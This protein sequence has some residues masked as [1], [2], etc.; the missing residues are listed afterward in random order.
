MKKAML[1]LFL[2]ALSLLATACSLAH[3]P[4]R[5]VV[6]EEGTKQ[7]LAGATVYVNWISYGSAAGVDSRTSCVRI[8]FATTDA[9][10]RF[11]LPWYSPLLPWGNAAAWV[12]AYK[13]GYERVLKLNQFGDFEDYQPP[14]AEQKIAMKS[15]RGT[16]KERLVYL[17]SQLGKEC[18]S[19]Y[20]YKKKLILYYRS[21]YEVGKAI[22]S[23]PDERKIVGSL[24]FSVEDLEL[25]H[26]EVLNRLT[27]G[28]YD[29]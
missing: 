4:I 27:S 16:V 26:K 11:E 9:Q 14:P 29:Q 23:R 2:A 19:P 28:Y 25:D 20:D 7:P 13:L 8:D 15:F 21:L 12:E 3:P 1:R 6:V 22:A 17:Q 18:G 24:L 5:G 10:G